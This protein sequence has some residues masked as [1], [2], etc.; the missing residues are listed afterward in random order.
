LRALYEL[1]E[2]DAF[3][4]YW[5]SGKPG[6]RMDTAGCDDTCAQALS[7]VN[8]LG[9]RT[10]AFLLDAGSGHP[11]VVCL[12]FGDGGSWPAVTIGLGTHANI[13][14]AL[15]KAVL[16]HGHYGPYIRQ[17][18]FE[19]RHHAIVKRS[20]VKTSIDHALYFAHRENVPDLS[21][22]RGDPEPAIALDVLR[23]RYRKEAS[24]A[25]CVSSLLEIGIRCAMVDVT[26]PD[27]GLSGMRVV[28]SFG[29]NLQPI[30][31]GFGYDRTQNPRLALNYSDLSDKCPHPIA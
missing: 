15:R 18:V 29:V 4:L 9:A 2:R 22:F 3:M 17:L 12:G 14:I 20:D 16:E 23:A 6:R 8:R 10:E 31:F 28:R 26:S 5:L 19:G 24:L 13:D 25:Q 30:H 21:F 7:E 11:T 1:I 27:V